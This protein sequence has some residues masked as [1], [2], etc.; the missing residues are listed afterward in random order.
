MTVPCKG[1][2]ASPGTRRACLGRVWPALEGKIHFLTHLCQCTEAVPQGH[3][4]AV[5]QGHCV[6]DRRAEPAKDVLFSSLS[7]NEH[8]GNAVRL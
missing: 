8:R 7:L 6:L 2:E 5:P 3:T 4:E 1:E